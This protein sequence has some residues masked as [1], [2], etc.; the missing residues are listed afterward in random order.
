MKALIL[1]ILFL[2][3][4]LYAQSDTDS[5][6]NVWNSNEQHDSL[7][8]DAMKKVV[9]KG[10]LFTKPDSSAYFA[11]MMYK[12]AVQKKYYDHS[13]YAM[14]AMGVSMYFQSRNKEAIQYYSKAIEIWDSLD[15]KWSVASASGNLGNVYVNIGDHVKAHDC[16]MKSIE[17]RRDLGYTKS[18]SSQYNNLGNNYWYQGNNEKALEYYFK[19]LEADRKND[20]K[21]GIAATLGNI[22]GVYNY[23]TDTALAFKYLTEGLEIS[24]EIGYSSAKAEC[25]KKFGIY[26]FNRKDYSQSLHYHFE[27]IE[28]AN[29]LND[30]QRMAFSYNYIGEI[31]L[32]KGD[33]SFRK[34]NRE[35]ADEYY[36]K[37]I[38]N[39]KMGLDLATEARV[40]LETTNAA[41][42]LY[43]TY[44]A[45]DSIDKA[46]EIVDLL[47]ER[48]DQD[49]K[50]NFSV[51]S[52]RGKELYFETM[53]D[54]YELFYDYTLRAEGGDSNLAGQAY[55]KALKLNGLML[56]SSSSLRRDIMKSSDSTLIQDFEDWLELKK[57]IAAEYSFGN[58][59]KDLEEKADELEKA[60]IAN[61]SAFNDL[62]KGKNLSWKD[63]SSKLL[64]SEAAVEFIRFERQKDVHDHSRKAITYCALIVKKNSDE[65]ELI[66]LFNESQLKEVLGNMPGN[67][68]N[69]ITQLYGTNSK[70]N[71]QLYNLIWS[72]IENSLKGSKDVYIAPAGLLHKVSFASLFNEKGVCLSNLYHI[73][74]VAS[75]SVIVEQKESA[76]KS[77]Y[78]VTAYGG[79]N[80]GSDSTGKETWLFLEGSKNEVNS[81]QEVL[82]E[83]EVQNS[84][85][86]GMNATE[87]VFKEKK[88]QSQ[89]IHIATH[90]FF[91][92]NPEEEIEI[93]KTEE[94]VS[95]RGGGDFSLWTFVKNKNALMRSGL[96]FKGANEIWD[97]TP[98]STGEDGLLT[99]LEVAAMD[100]S[101]TQLVVLSAC[102]TGLGDI[103]GSEGV[104]GLQRSFK[105]A[106]V[107]YLIMSLWQV[108]DKE[109]AEFM[110]SFYKNLSKTED[111]KKSFNL[112]QKEMRKK[113]DPYY[114]AAFVLVE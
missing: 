6:L 53:Q 66:E 38:E 37:A 32:L 82:G 57:H 45:V 106:G 47:L 7:R 28:L 58:D 26:Y 83:N 104:Y 11:K 8:F 73:H 40:S 41:V 51:L 17:I 25:L 64:P 59:T 91:F 77:D 92:P 34:Q 103:K 93:D 109:T 70:P 114:W 68:F 12:E 105:M 90:G 94:D 39:S 112:T 110:I 80:Y 35:K 18:I 1:S 101:S 44:L 19:S 72:P 31:F 65:P 20:N 88:N 111:I 4:T 76:L 69:Y 67:N 29:T 108:P 27:N 62:E 9:W 98:K 42:V 74:N 49:L 22:G 96:V 55:D 87:E 10:Y 2:A 100:L 107:D 21:K 60:L 99:A 86:L 36:S 84:V 79:V 75:T 95:F 81:I 43:K 14:N 16:F 5:L 13:A 54:D 50:T 48:R 63:V 102:E 97:R 52:E 113:Y 33:S 61:N 78:N 85:Y 24:T 89:I 46:G 15:N 23:T 3:N 71:N 56:K 30:K